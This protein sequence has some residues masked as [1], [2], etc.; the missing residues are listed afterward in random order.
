MSV[1]RRLTKREIAENKVKDLG[2]L[3]LGRI[4]EVLVHPQTGRERFAIIAFGAFLGSTDRLFAV[5]WRSLSMDD[6]TGTYFLHADRRTLRSAPKFSRAE[7]QSLDSQ[8]LGLVARHFRRGSNDT[9]S[10]AA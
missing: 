2:G 5:P 7:L 10:A 6:L 1:A 4:E 9:M 3:D 8:H